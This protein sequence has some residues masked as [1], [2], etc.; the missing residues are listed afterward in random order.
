MT[1]LELLKAVSKTHQFQKTKVGA[2][3]NAQR[4]VYDSIAKRGWIYM[5]DLPEG[6][7]INWILSQKDSVRRRWLG[8][9]KSPSQK[10]AMKSFR[11][12]KRQQVKRDIREAVSD[13]YALKQEILEMEVEQEMARSAQDCLDMVEQEMQMDELAAAKWA[14]LRYWNLDP[15][16]HDDMMVCMWDNLMRDRI[17]GSCRQ[18]LNACHE[19]DRR[20]NSHQ[21]YTPAELRNEIDYAWRRHEA[22]EMARRNQAR[23]KM[24]HE[25]ACHEAYE[26]LVETI[27]SHDDESHRTQDEMVAKFNNKHA[28][29]RRK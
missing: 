6:K 1:D 11:S 10:R 7:D 23:S 25:I 28:K 21:A 13:H 22:D 27:E 8:D 20:N 5:Y 24:Y 4:M 2:K 17:I 15:E 9:A 3:Y 19:R 26:D 29:N 16:L 18:I 12:G 14:F